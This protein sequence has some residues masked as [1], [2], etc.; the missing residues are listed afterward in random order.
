MEKEKVDRYIAGLLFLLV[1]VI[2]VVVTAPTLN[3]SNTGSLVGP[4]IGIFFGVL[5]AGSL[6]KPDVLGPI[7]TEMAKRMA[8]N[9]TKDDVSTGKKQEI[10][11]TQ[12][13]AKIQGDVIT[14]VATKD[15]DASIGTK[16]TKRK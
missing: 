16:G 11:V 14:Q 6:W 1:G 2:I 7:V 10:H 8:Q 3:L 9:A 13:I 12:N 4:I 5:G 15:T